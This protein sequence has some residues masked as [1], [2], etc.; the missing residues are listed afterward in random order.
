MNNRVLMPTYMK[1]FACIGGECED[2]C[3]AGWQ[4]TLDKKSY[5]TYKN[6]KDSQL[7]KSLQKSMK[8][9]KSDSATPANY[10][11]FHLDEHGRCP[12][13]NQEN[14]CSIQLNVG[15][16][17]L[18]PTCKTY[19]R[20]L[21]RV[22]GTNEMSAKLSCPEIARLVLLNKEKME[23][24]EVEIPLNP[25]WTLF[26]TLDT[27][28]PT[29]AEK[30]FWNIRVFTIDV[31]QNREWSVEDRLIFLGLFIRKLEQVLAQRRFDDIPELIQEYMGKMEDPNIQSSLDTIRGDVKMQMHIIMHL[32]SHRAKLGV[33]NDRYVEC[34]KE[35]LSGFGENIGNIMNVNFLEEQYLYNYTQYYEPFMREHSYMLENYLV[36]HVFEKLFPQNGSQLFWDYTLMVII[37]MMVRIHLIGISG[38][39]KQL[40][41]EIIVKVVQSFNRVIMHSSDYLESI[42]EFFIDN[43]IDSLA[44]VVAIL[45]TRVTE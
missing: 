1:S 17:L 45:S 29:F 37:F 22:D 9:N 38:H 41:D 2:S 40:N 42:K 23:C 39:Y 5:K 18:S 33:S 43:E 35:M 13:L 32:V 28:S 16:D 4:V 12:M 6:L 36:N 20:V 3:C 27:V 31:L 21:N 19:P 15:E 24:E 7:A 11:S 26:N 30:Y 25:S 10:A 34:F 44:H 14:L 8:R